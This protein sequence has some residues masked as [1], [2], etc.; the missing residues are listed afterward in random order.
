MASLSTHL[1]LAGPPRLGILHLRLQA[2]AQLVLLGHLHL[3]ALEGRDVLAQV[4]PHVGD[5]VGGHREG[6]GGLV[7]EFGEVIGHFGRHVG[8]ELQEEREDEK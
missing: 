2:R 6:I 8:I 7:L 5:L 1:S 3:E 4:V